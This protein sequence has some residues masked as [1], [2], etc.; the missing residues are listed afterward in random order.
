M[1]HLD[2][3]ALAHRLNAA[4][5]RADV[6]G[7]GVARFVFAEAGRRAV[8]ISVAGVGIW[9]EYWEDN[10]VGKID[11]TFPTAEAALKDAIA[12]LY[13]GAG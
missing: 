13:G 8:E 3:N 4:G 6:R 10:D 9:I 1:A 2:H 12:W 7:D 11:R 5:F